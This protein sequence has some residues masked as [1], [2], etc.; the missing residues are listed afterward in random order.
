MI[1]LFS[2]QLGELRRAIDE[3][4]SEAIMASFNRAKS[5]RDHFSEVLKKRQQP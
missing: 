5:A 1:D 2:A 3:A 4:D